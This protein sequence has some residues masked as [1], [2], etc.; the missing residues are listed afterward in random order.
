[1]INTDGKIN[2]IIGAV[3]SRCTSLS[4]DGGGISSPAARAYW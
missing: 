1:L 2:A 4:Q 3:A